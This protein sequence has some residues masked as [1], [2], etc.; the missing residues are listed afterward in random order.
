MRLFKYIYISV[1]L[2]LLLPVGICATS[3]N[4][5]IELSEAERNW[6]SEEHLVRVRVSDFPPFQFNESKLEGISVDIIT[7]ILNANNIK[8]ELVSSEGYS[9]AESLDL[10]KRKEIFDLF[11]TASIFEERKSFLAFTEEYIK[12][13]GV[14][15]AREV[16]P[17]ISS[18]DDLNGKVVSTPESFVIEQLLREG[19]P[20][21][22]LKTY[23]D[24]DEIEKCLIALANGEV[25]AYIGGLAVGM[26]FIKHLGLVNVKPVAPTPFVNH[27]QAFAV[28]KDWSELASI[29]SKSLQQFSPK[30][31]SEIFNKWI[32]VSYEPGFDKKEVIKWAVVL[33][34]LFI[35]IQVIS[36][37]WNEKL[38]REIKSRK[39]S[40]NKFNL[41]FQNN[42]SSVVLLDA[43]DLTF[44]EV[45]K[46]F[47]ELTGYTS[48]EVIGKTAYELGIIRDK[49]DNSDFVDIMKKNSYFG[50][51]HITFYTKEGVKVDG[52]QFGE[53]III[54][55]K[56]YYLI[57]LIDVTKQRQNQQ[58]IAFLLTLQSKLRDFSTV[59]INMD[60]DKINEAFNSI[61]KEIGQL[62]GADRAY[63]F[64]YDFNKN[65]V[66]EKYEWYSEGTEPQFNNLQN[67]DL[68]GSQDWLK[69]HKTGCPVIVSRLEDEPDGRIKRDMIILKTK[70]ILA[71]PT[72]VDN[73]LFGFVGIDYVHNEHIIQDIDIEILNFFGQIYIN[74][75]ARIKYENK[76]TELNTQ[77]T[78]TTTTA[79]QYAEKS[80]EACKAKSDF[81]ATMSHEIRTPLNGVIGFTELLADT[82]LNK[83]QRNYI[84][85]ANKSAHS[86]LNIINDILDFSKIEAGKL[87]LDYLE[88]DIYELF[89]EIIDLFKL[90]AYNKGI[91]LFVDIDSN[92]PKIVM[93]DIIRFKQVLIN[94]LSNAIKFTDKGSVKLIAEFK[95]E[96]EKGILTV[97]VIDT[98]IGIEKDQVNKLF[99][100][101]SQAD[102]SVTRKFGGTGLGL[103]ISNKIINQMGGNIV[104]DSEPNIKT[105]FE[106]SLELDYIKNKPFNHEMTPSISRILLIEKETSNIPEILLAWGYDVTIAS[107]F[108][109]T[110]ELLNRDKF[111]LLFVAYVLPVTKEINCL[112]EITQKL[113]LAIMPI[114]FVDEIQGNKY[115]LAECEKLDVGNFIS[116][117]I[118][119]TNLQ[120]KLI[121]I[122]NNF[123]LGF[124]P[125]PLPVRTT[126]KPKT[127]SNNKYSILIAEDNRLNLKLITTILKQLL[128]NTTIDSAINGKIAQD[129]ATKRLY[130]LILMDLQMPEM[131]GMT[132]TK[133]IIDELNSN[134]PPIIALTANASQED[135]S[136]CL[137][138]GMTGFLTKPILKD[139]LIEVLRR[140][141]LR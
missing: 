40:E 83:S 119:Q 114:L 104:F 8:Y 128:P 78:E 138:L 77:L 124:K 68:S 100:A 30:L 75:M 91:E 99:K 32:A 47:I 17:F 33:V 140:N 10:I 27:A 111:D 1:V 133:L 60:S 24:G 21:I 15:F 18:V 134:T 88:N 108:E 56:D 35:I 90:K 28:R 42:P 106:F 115:L 39:Q 65:T 64:E 130:D 69:A 92:L 72:F 29:I 37:Y 7:E 62:Y 141:L 50:S 110:L 129:K 67:I 79:R 44:T 20:D 48:D 132:A 25:D 101:F 122:N 127:L 84:R 36:L 85:Y 46:M 70:S 116:K 109:E 135:R 120:Q 89:D 103:I 82:D 43:S 23:G 102:T 59:L 11:L 66:T 12:L 63:V 117:P 98:G 54:D 6:I 13:P 14:I 55:E 53:T 113:N 96:K 107:S 87:D 76:L 118:R 3:H 121:S 126:Y 81:L 80:K 136:R 105:I 97:K 123:A 4:I 95:E 73:K 45:N 22:N 51:I 38:K 34:L 2:V 16:I 19:Y 86:L 61:L 139:K 112:K 94:L 5:N 57:T 74:T 52:L 71:V 41:L 31:R 26:Y 49:I 58:Q 125:T 93:I 9:W 137:R 131:D